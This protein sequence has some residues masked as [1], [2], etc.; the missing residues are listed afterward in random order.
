ML[1]FKT[2]NDIGTIKMLNYGVLLHLPPV[3]DINSGAGKIV[4]KIR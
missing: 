4:R 1:R 3:V 2:I